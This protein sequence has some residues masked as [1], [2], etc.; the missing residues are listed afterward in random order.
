MIFKRFPAFGW[1][2]RHDIIALSVD[3]STVNT[4]R[5]DQMLDLVSTLI[6]GY[7]PKSQLKPESLR[8]FDDYICKLKE[9]ILL[10]KGV[11]TTNNSEDG[12]SKEQM[13]ALKSLTNLIKIMSSALRKC[14]KIDPSGAS[15][16]KIWPC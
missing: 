4:Y 3:S 10:L 7:P 12:L 1:L 14:L 8:E 13:A 6:I 9:A 5:R 16:L 11:V 2:L 15:C